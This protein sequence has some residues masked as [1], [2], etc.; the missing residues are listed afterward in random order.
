MSTHDITRHLHKPRK[1]YASVRMQVRRTITDAD[2][3]EG[4]QVREETARRQ[5][6]RIYERDPLL[7]A[8]EHAPLAARVE[9]FWRTERD[10]A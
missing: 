6:Q 4:E 1:H 10:P 5:A 9:A 3:N 2:W 7:T 8:P